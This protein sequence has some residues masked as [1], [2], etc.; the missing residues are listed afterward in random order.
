MCS[1]VSICE[2]FDTTIEVRKLDER[3]T[4]QGIINFIGMYIHILL[5]LLIIRSVPF[6]YEL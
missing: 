1:D 2:S 6:F 5:K 3:K 4:N